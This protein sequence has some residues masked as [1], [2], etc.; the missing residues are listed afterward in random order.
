MILLRGDMRE[1]DL[2]NQR[3]ATRN[4][5]KKQRRKIDMRGFLKKVVRVVSAIV[6]TAMITL[7]CYEI[8]GFAGRTTF[9]SL[10]QID[11]TGLKRLTRA[12]ILSAA[13]V[14]IGDD[15]L[16]LRLSRMGEQLAKNPWVASVK[17]RRNFPHS[18]AI[19]IV[20]RE[21]VGIVS[22]GYLYYLD[23]RG[24][25]FK[26]LQEGD[27]LD[28]P[29]V[30]GLSEDDIQRDPAGARE[31]LRGVLDMLQLMQKANAG[32]SAADISE[33]HYDKGFGYT[34]F[35]MSHGLPIRVG[36]GGFS[37]KL[38]RLARIYKDLQPQM[39]LLEYIDL[40]Y[41]DRIIV[42]RV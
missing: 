11:I 23:S 1:L 29:V 41:H 22:M 8:Y 21:P 3:P 24:E 39:P 17:V 16:A 33:I 35:T 42:K 36:T 20:E 5:F 27:R 2:N 40:D 7:A 14:R 30:T 10:D 31:S 37:E 32:I 19:E 26:P 25:I 38:E 4:R 12:E 13:A 34:L 9:L 18:L 6:I 15:L 28:F